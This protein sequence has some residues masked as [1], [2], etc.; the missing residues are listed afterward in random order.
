MK[1]LFDF[2][3]YVRPIIYLIDNHCIKNARIV[4]IEAVEMFEYD[5]LPTY[6]NGNSIEGY[7]VGKYGDIRTS[8][9]W[10]SVL[11]EYRKFL[12]LN[13]SIELSEQQELNF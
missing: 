4:G 3:K 12:E 5:L 2:A 10:E 7:S 11:F 9:E 13:L 1:S 6:D 8:F